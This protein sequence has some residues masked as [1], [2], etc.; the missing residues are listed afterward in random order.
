AGGS[1]R[2]RSA[3]G[4]RLRLY[5]RSRG[6]DGGPATWGGAEWNRAGTQGTHGGWCGAWTPGVGAVRKVAD[7]GSSA[8]TEIEGTGM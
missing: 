2:S 8:G 3:S 4:E 6:A 1:Q 7:V 5:C